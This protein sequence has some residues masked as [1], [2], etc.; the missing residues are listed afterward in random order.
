MAICFWA[1]QI[2]FKAD[3]NF[4]IDR[5]EIEGG[6]LTESQGDGVLKELNKWKFVQYLPIS[7]KLLGNED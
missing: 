6:F 4:E 5:A 1:E 2:V 3:A 7:N